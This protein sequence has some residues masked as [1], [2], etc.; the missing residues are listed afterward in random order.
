MDYYLRVVR[1]QPALQA[2]KIS[3]TVAVR[4]GV[5]DPEHSPGSYFKA[6]PGEEI[7]NTIRMNTPWFEPNGQCPFYKARL[8]PGQ[9]YPRIARPIDQYPLEAPGW[10]PGARHEADVIAIARSQLIVLTRQLE[11]ICQTVHPTNQT[12][13]TFGHDI[14]NL[15]I[16][17]CTEVET[18]WRGVLTAN[19][20]K[21][22]RYTTK[23][24]VQLVPALKLNDYAVTFPGYPWLEAIQP[25]KDWGST[26]MP[27]KELKWYEAYNAVK[28][29]RETEFE[30][31]TL[32]SVF[33]AVSACYIMM[34]AQFGSDAGIRNRS[35]LS[36][37]FQLSAVPEWSPSEV[38][39]Y[40]YG[41]PCSKW[42]PIDFSF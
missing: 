12:F 25:Y 41:E 32:R 36:S 33:E 37:F 7:W 9:Y 27:T 28:H 24:Y 2:W 10:S 16:L 11:R 42:S 19:G 15:L 13:E 5:A 26:G 39:I 14:R 29:N 31:A 23:E 3:P 18:H 30:R 21:G 20:V 34:A 4:I 1:D 8:Q 22:D 38:Y 35:A 17:A 6:A 40:P